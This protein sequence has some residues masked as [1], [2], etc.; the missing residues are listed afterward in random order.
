MLDEQGYFRKGECRRGESRNCW[1]KAVYSV[2]SM[3][4]W[5]L[6]VSYRHEIKKY[7]V[8]CARKRRHD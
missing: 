8:L 1:M 5:D 2:S 7:F 6:K 4:G 3:V